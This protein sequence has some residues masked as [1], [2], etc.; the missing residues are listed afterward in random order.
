MG[1]DITIDQWLVL[2]TLYENKRLSQSQ[3]ATRVFKD[4][5]SITRILD[6]LVKKKYIKRN[7]NLSDGRKSELEITRRGISIIAN[8]YPIIIE[9]RKQALRGLKKNE[10]AIVKLYLEKITNNCK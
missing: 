3:L 4:V 8:I 5:A 6:L 10:I 2:K 9:N 1:Y 7:P